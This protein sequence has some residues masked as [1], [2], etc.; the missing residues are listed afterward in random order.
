VLLF[1][2]AFGEHLK[3]IGDRVCTSLNLNIFIHH[4]DHITMSFE[5]KDYLCIHL[6]ERHLSVHCFWFRSSFFNPSSIQLHWISVC[7]VHS[8]IH[9]NSSL[10]FLAA[11]LGLVFLTMHYHLSKTAGKFYMVVHSTSRDE[12]LNELHQAKVR[13]PSRH[14]NWKW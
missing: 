6:E 12:K 4:L 3:P 13:K 7:L 10:Y 8:L 2:S 14:Y 1:F 5:C 9:T 11:L